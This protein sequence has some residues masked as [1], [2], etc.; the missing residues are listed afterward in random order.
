MGLK[1]LTG[2][3][4]R[5]I[6]VH[7]WCAKYGFIKYSKLVFCSDSS[8]STDYHNQ[9]NSEVCKSWF[10]QMLNNLEKPS[11]IVMNNA[12]YHSTLVDNFQ[13][14]I[15]KIECS[16]LVEK[17]NVNFSPLETQAELREKVKSLIPYE[18]KYK[19]KEL[20]L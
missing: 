6:V 17:K 3:R 5:L 7:A 20:V 13:K 18:K 19:L 16:K 15:K 14:A 9:M 12:L 8:N 11:V 1:I 2:K 10:T 4:G